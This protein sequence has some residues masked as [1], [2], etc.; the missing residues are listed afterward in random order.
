MYK[1]SEISE[2]S[3]TLCLRIPQPDRHASAVFPPLSVQILPNIS[4]DSELDNH[5][6]YGNVKI[7]FASLFLQ[8]Q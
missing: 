2:D 4:T 5:G 3:A 7:I 8:A 6:I 1:D